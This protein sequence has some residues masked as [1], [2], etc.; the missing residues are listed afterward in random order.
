MPR[1][2]V[3]YVAMSIDGFIAEADGSVAWLDEYNAEGADSGYKEFYTTVDALIMGATTYEQLKGWDLAFPYADKPCLVASGRSG[4][5]P[6]ADTVR[7]VADP[8]AEVT[9]LRAAEGDGVVWVVGGGK[10]AASLWNAGV[11]DE[12]RIFVMPTV[13]GG[14]VPLFAPPY[15]RRRVRRTLTREHGQGMVELRYRVG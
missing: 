7:V 2:S 15:D 13:L 1:P 8:V 10:L 5:E 12:L 14:G 11:L 3:Y 4:L 6:A 9:A